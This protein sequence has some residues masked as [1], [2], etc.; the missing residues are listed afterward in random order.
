MWGEDKATGHLKTRTP[1]KNNLSSVIPPG[2]FCPRVNPRRVRAPEPTDSGGRIDELNATETRLDTRLVGNIYTS[3][4]RSLVSVCFCL[5]L[6]LKKDSDGGSVVNGYV[7]YRCKNG[8]SGRCPKV[9]C[10]L[11]A[12]GLS[13]LITQTLYDIFTYI[14]VGGFRGHCRSIYLP[15]MEWLYGE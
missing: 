11:P 1:P 9:V 10:S 6:G 12:P 4:L 5:S 2:A 8:A 14:G 7:Y 15:Y 13:W 3:D